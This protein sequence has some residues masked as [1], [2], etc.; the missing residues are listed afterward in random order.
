MEKKLITEIERY[1]EIMGLNSLNEKYE[2]L[3][4]IVDTYPNITFAKYTPLSLRC[5]PCCSIFNPCLK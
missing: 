4:R 2:N 5:I 3:P 1:K